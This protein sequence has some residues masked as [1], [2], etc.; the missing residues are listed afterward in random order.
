MKNT[1][2]FGAILLIVGSTRINGDT[3]D[4]SGRLLTPEE[5]CG[6]TKVKFTRIVGGSEAKNGSWPWISLL[7][8]EKGNETFFDCGKKK[9]M[10]FSFDCLT[11]ISI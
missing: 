3:T 9:L 7:A 2:L 5:G 4:T 6:H 10:T 11:R 1:L 8:Y